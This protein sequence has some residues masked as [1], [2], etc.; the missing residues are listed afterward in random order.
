MNIGDKKH[1]A[2]LLDKTGHAIANCTVD[3]DQES[4]HLFSTY[5]STTIAI[6]ASTHSP[7]FSRQL[8]YWVA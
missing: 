7:W 4:L 3:N 6:E 2:C 5:K 1:V 8:T